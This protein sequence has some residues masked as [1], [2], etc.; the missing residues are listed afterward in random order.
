MDITSDLLPRI[1]KE[2]LGG[3]QAMQHAQMLDYSLMLD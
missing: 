2:Q 3:I 1:V